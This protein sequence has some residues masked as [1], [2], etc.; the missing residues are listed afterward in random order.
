MITL[1]DALQRQARD[2]PDAI[3]LE[4]D[5]ETCSYAQ[6]A[7]TVRSLA[8]GLRGLGFAPGDRI[9]LYLDKSIRMVAMLLASLQA[10]CVAVPIN[11]KLKPAQ[12]LH[13]LKDCEAS[14]VVATSLRANELSRRE[15]LWHA[16]VLL[17][18]SLPNP[19]PEPTAGSAPLY[20]EQ[21]LSNDEY[22]SPPPAPIDADVALLIYTSGSTG[23]PKGVVVS[24]R[25]VI[26]GAE[27]VAS[28]L[29]IGRADVILGLLPL[30][31]DAGFSQLSTAIVS[32][33]R[34]V[35]HNYT[36][37]RFVPALCAASKV[38]LITAIPPLWSQ[39]AAVSWGDEALTVRTIANTGGHMPA[40]L[41]KSLRAL[42]PQA[43]PFLM[44]GLTEA[45][46]STYL[47]PAE[48]DHRP[49]SIGKAIPNAEIL[50]LRADGS[51]CAPGEHGE[52]VHRGALV[53]LGYW[54]NKAKTRERFRVLPPSITL[55]PL[56]EY[57]VWSG[58][59]VRTD[60][61]GFIYF[62]GRRDELMKISGY[63]VS[64]TEIEKVVMRAGGIRET[65]VIGV[66][67]D[68]L[69]T[70][71]VALLVPEKVDFDSAVALAHCKRELP[72]YMVP[73]L[74]VCEALAHS[75]NG[76]LDRAGSREL[77]L[78]MLQGAAAV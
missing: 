19:E 73:K 2:T 4:H 71:P 69:G 20:W 55:S 11:P 52:L 76:K 47:D 62:V 1:L 65:V 24:H 7:T 12:V 16:R 15:A 26:A 59:I 8:H 28:Y 75:P 58:D 57:A 53:T 31:F 54:N 10:G 46:R 63:R 34:L 68:A 6:L 43:R 13:V 32:G 44:Y 39:L 45:F 66:A 30:S 33:A 56:P 61:D 41:L 50:V 67:D 27:S 40:T 48:I 36:S 38:T 22:A 18:D 17:T 42:F 60:E 9:A 64:P 77:Y 78:R 3:A 70:A 49:D 14:A 51:R 35:L 29:G 23:L 21:C 37:A 72:A 5:G 74:V 25:N